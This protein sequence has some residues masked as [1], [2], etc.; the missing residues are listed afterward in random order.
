MSKKCLSL[1]LS[2]A[3]L[4]FVG[5]SKTEEPKTP[6]TPPPVA[7][8]APAPAA[9]AGVTVGTINVG[10]SIDAD[11][12]IAT[13]METFAKGDTIY[14]TVD[15]TGSGPAT[16]K[17]KWTYMKGGQTTVVKEDTQM[18]SPTGPATTEFHIDKP[19]GWPAGDYQVE[20]FVDDKSVGTKTFTVK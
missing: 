12:K 9:P 11:K 13:P 6:A 18:I 19:G 20:I 17:A 7:E 3:L 15:T 8:P 4:S 10:K 14:V 1:L 5:C 16:V 2:T